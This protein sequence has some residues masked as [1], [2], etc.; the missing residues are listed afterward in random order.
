M[1]VMKQIYIR[2]NRIEHW[3]HLRCAGNRLAQYTDTW[4]CYQHKESRLTINT[5]N[6][7]PP[8]QTL[9]QAAHPPNTT[10]TTATKAQTPLSIYLLEKVNQRTTKQLTQ[11][12]NTA[13]SKSQ[14]TTLS[15]H[16][17]RVRT[18]HFMA[19]IH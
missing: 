12:Y 19:L 16:M 15:P 9:D 1:Q 8:S 13:Y 18:L 3:L 6:T 11:T 5:L 2:C 7:T 4:T 17:G 10:H 14:N